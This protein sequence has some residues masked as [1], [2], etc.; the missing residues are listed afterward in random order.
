MRVPMSWLSELVGDGVLPGP[1]EVA[2]AFVRVGLEVEEIHRP[3]EITGPLVV[4]RVAAIEELSGLKKPIRYCQVEVGRRLD[5]P[6]P[7][8]ASSAAHA[9]S[10][11]ATSSWW[12]CPAPC[13]RAASRSPPARPTVTSPTA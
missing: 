12:R 2:E 9:T 10:P 7:G 1:A 6:P 5:G 11:S 4:G 13:C 3:A 8:T